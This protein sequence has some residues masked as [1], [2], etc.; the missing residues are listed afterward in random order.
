MTR[1]DR[2]ILPSLIIA[3]NKHYVNFEE[4]LMTA[5]PDRGRTAVAHRSRLRVASAISRAVAAA[6]PTTASATR[7]R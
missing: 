2:A 5:A 3:H 6:N 1:A 7:R 4:W